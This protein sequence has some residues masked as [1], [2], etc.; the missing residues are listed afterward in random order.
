[1]AMRAGSL[2][3][4][5]HDL[6]KLVATVGEKV[7]LSP[8]VMRRILNHTAPKTDVLHRHYGRLGMQDVVEGLTRIQSEMDRLCPGSRPAGA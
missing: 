2:R 3:F 1:M 8:A 6:R 5:L 4:M 7:G